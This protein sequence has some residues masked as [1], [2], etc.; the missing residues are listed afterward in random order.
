M[1]IFH[2]AG[3]APPFG[4]TSR[5]PCSKPLCAI[6]VW[7]SAVSGAASSSNCRRCGDPSQFEAI[8]LQPRCL[9]F[10]RG[11]LLLPFKVLTL[12]AGLTRV[13]ITAE[14]GAVRAAL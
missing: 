4:V 7:N 11:D 1:F 5:N 6:R 2:A 10:R 14:T 3:A 8:A 9:G 13:L 12:H